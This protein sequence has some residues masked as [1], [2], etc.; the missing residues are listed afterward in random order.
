MKN[1]IK[2]AIIILIGLNVVVPFFVLKLGYFDGKAKTAAFE[3]QLEDIRRKNASISALLNKPD[4]VANIQNEL[5][6][7]IA[8][9]RELMP[10]QSELI[11]SQKSLSQFAREAGVVIVALRPLSDSKPL[12]I[13]EDKTA[14]KRATADQGDEEKGSVNI[15]TIELKVQGSYDNI[16][17]YIRM[18][19]D[20]KDETMI[21][22][23]LDMVQANEE[24]RV[25][26]EADITVKIFFT[27]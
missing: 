24:D 2:I 23:G 26:I 12:I 5:S 7:E 17:N 13:D 18:I 21:V 3:K 19:E 4:A 9:L 10:A 25:F 6:E 16:C 22:Q 1:T 27:V 20:C 15:S 8:V 14:E 11:A